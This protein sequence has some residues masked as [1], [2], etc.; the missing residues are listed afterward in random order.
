V[1]RDIVVKP[2]LWPMP[3]ELG[4]NQTDHHRCHVDIC[5]YIFPNLDDDRQRVD[6]ENLQHHHRRRPLGNMDY[7][8]AGSEAFV[9]AGTTGA[10]LLTGLTSAFGSI[11]QCLSLAATH[12]AGAVTAVAATGADAGTAGVLAGSV[13]KAA[14]ATKVA[15]RVAIVFISKVPLG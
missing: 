4:H 10:W 9:A 3:I 13:A 11:L 8:L 2:W 15:I 14:V 6:L 5:Q 1:F 7:F 12:L